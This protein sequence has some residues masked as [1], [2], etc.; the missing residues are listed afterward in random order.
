[1]AKV[2]KAHKSSKKY[3]FQRSTKKTIGTVVAVVLVVAALI[4]G[5]VVYNNTRTGEIAVTAPS[6]ETL[7]NIA[8]NWQTLAAD[9]SNFYNY[10]SSN[11]DG[12]DGSGSTMLYYFGN[13]KAD[14]V[15]I[16]VNTAELLENTEDAAAVGSISRTSLFSA[17]LGQL[18]SGEVS[19]SDTTVVLQA[20]NENCLLYIVDAEAETLDDSLLNEIIAELEA[21]IAAAPAVEETVEETAETVEST[22]EAAE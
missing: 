3:S 2:H 19:L 4:V 14:Q 17:D 21:V 8:A 7:N 6:H 5:L 18:F 13:E 10:Y 16:Y 22:D 20:G 15:Q 1:M 11:E 9:A 12:T